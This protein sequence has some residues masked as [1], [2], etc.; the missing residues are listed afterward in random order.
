[1]PGGTGE[2]HRTVIDFATYRRLATC[3]Q[4]RDLALVVDADLTREAIARAAFQM[5][6]A[7][8]AFWFMFWAEYAASS[9]NQ[10]SRF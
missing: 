7:P 8:V 2:A 6:P 3:R 1:M 4:N 9:G 5:I 10:R